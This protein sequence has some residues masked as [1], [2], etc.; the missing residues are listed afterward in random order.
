MVWALLGDRVGDNAQV[1]ALSRSTGWP[2]KEQQLSWR[3]PKPI[4]TPFYGRRASLSALTQE[5][6]D[7]II[8]P[9][10]D[11]V[12]AVGWRSVPVARWI[13]AQNGAR[14]VH[15]GRPRAPLEVFDLVLTTPQYGLPPAKNVVRLDRPLGLSAAPA[16]DEAARAWR[17]RLAH[18]PRPWI[19]VLVGGSAPPLVLRPREGA[20]LG[21]A[22]AV[23]AR[24]QGGSLLVVGGPRTRR[25][26]LDALAGEIDTGLEVSHWTGGQ[27]NPYR[28][29]LGIADSFIV[30]SDSVSMMYEAALQG[31]PLHIF[32][33]PHRI[34]AFR[35]VAASLRRLPGLGGLAR[36]ARRG[37]WVPAP[38]CSEAVV[39]RLVGE[40]RAVRLGQHADFSPLGT[41]LDPM[42]IALAQLSLVA[43]C[44]LGVPDAAVHPAD[45]SAL[46]GA[47]D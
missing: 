23:L 26:V 46:R 38:R 15:L 14:L 27:E 4:W 34:Q 41:M 25:D 11:I 7:R 24:A 8:P 19:A 40:G 22:A 18:L 30:T 32:D 17:A 12:I 10:P 29:W 39:E 9:W 37:G 36:A 28:A 16:A 1:R 3:R 21:R 5:A 20:R 43:G 47:S 2:C 31:R 42:E 35:R 13:A 44:S 6:R 45:R 33:V